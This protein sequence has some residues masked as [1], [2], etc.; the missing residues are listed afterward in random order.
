MN[1]F[2]L[3][4]AVPKELAPLWGFLAAR[5][6]T[7]GQYACSKQRPAAERRMR[8]TG[9]RVRSLPPPQH[10]HNFRSVPGYTQASAAECLCPYEWGHGGHGRSG[11]W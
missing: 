9:G 2:G 6:L 11:R 5:G 10:R 7:G 3:E 1:A 8:A 4:D